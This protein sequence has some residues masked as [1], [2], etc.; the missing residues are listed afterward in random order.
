MNVKPDWELVR[1][2]V[3]SG[4]AQ[5]AFS[6]LIERYADLVHGCCLRQ[7]GEAEAAADVSQAVHMVFARGERR[8]SGGA[9]RSPGGCLRWPGIVRGIMCEPK[10][11]GGG[12]KRRSRQ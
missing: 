6:E 4:S 9:R 7:T 2:Y 5:A 1:E 10:P 11:V 3:D 8:R 12:A